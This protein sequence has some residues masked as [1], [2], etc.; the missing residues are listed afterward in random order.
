MHDAQ[1]ATLT[2]LCLTSADPAFP[3]FRVHHAFGLC[4]ILSRAGE[5]ARYRH[6][7]PKRNDSSARRLRGTTRTAGSPRTPT[8][9]RPRPR[10]CMACTSGRRCTRPRDRRAARRRTAAPRRPATRRRSQSRP[11][12]A[13]I[14]LKVEQPSQNW[15]VK[16]H[17][18]AHTGGKTMQ[19]DSIA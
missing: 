18:T 11:R 16:C 2:A 13:P 19:G 5:R 3:A 17:C 10:A 6:S 8:R 4:A 1:L 9:A 12:G 7:A 15:N 14:S